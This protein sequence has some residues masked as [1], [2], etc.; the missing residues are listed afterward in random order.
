M[1]E[2][3]FRAWVKKTKEMRLVAQMDLDCFTGSGIHVRPFGMSHPSLQPKQ[4]I[5]MQFTGLVDTKGV[6]IYDGDILEF[7]RKDKRK[8]KF[9]INVVAWNEEALQFSYKALGTEHWNHIRHIKKAIG[10]G[11]TFK[12]IGNI[13]ENSDLLV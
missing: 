11:C 2:I 5:L 4:I 8:S 3:K 6:A 13:H 7:R 1:Q 12:V 10:E 9:P